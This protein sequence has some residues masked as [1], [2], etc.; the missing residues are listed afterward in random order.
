M[1]D[2]CFDG[3]R[4]ET[5]AVVGGIGA[6]RSGSRAGRTGRA[7]RFR[8]GAARWRLRRARDDGRVCAAARAVRPGHRQL[9]GDQAPARGPVGGLRGGEVGRVLR[10]L[11][12]G[13]VPRRHGLGPAISPR[14]RPWSGAAA[15]RRS[16]SAAPMRSSSTAA[17]A[18]PGSTMRSSISSARA[19]RSTYLGSPDYHREQ[20][21]RLIGLDDGPSALPGG[22]SMKLG[23]TPPGGGVPPRVRRSGSKEQLSRSLPRDRAA[24]PGS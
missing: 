21:A 2:S 14:L 8:G 20:I 9:P 17:S 5:G 11:H 6:G 3:V 23:F 13:R 16:C 12:R 4:V 15:R 1:R 7:G 18:S 24:S 22:Q 10:G 19:R